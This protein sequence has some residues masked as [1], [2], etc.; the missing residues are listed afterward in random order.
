MLRALKYL[1]LTLLIL[2][3]ILSGLMA[4]IVFAFD[5]NTLKPTI[6][7]QVE[8]A[9]GRKLT[10]NGPITWAFTPLP[11][12]VINDISFANRAGFGKSPMV[13]AKSIKLGLNAWPRFSPKFT[14]GINLDLNQAKVNLTVK[15]NGQSNWQDLAAPAKP[16][17]KMKEQPATLGP[18]YLG[19]IRLTNASV[20][21]QNM[22][23]KQRIVLN[24]IDYRT[25]VTIVD[26]E[27]AATNLLQAIHATGHSQIK[28]LTFNNVKMQNL[29]GRLAL[30][31]GVMT[32][33]PING[34]LY[35]GN[36][37]GSVKLDFN[38]A[39]AT[40]AAN[41]SIYQ[42]RA[43]LLFKD[44]QYTSRL[45]GL[46]QASIDVTSQN[47]ERIPNTLNGKISFKL[48]NGV[49]KGVNIPQTIQTI[50]VLVKTRSIPNLSGIRGDT[51]F[52]NLS[53]EGVI[54]NGKFVIQNIALESPNLRITGKG[55]IDLA[56]QT[57]NFNL[58]ASGVGGQLG[59]N[60]LK[61]QQVMGGAIP[62]NIT[63]SMAGFSLRPE[64]GAILPA[65]AKHLVIDRA[66]D[67]KNAVEK[68]GGGVKKLLRTLTD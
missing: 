19:N 34:R 43:G 56:A 25:K 44:L 29:N 5:P 26:E 51:Q 12:V 6:T 18:F 16:S 7:S 54:K 63:G 37:Q 41:Q 10:I 28:S 52:I 24:G 9:T 20:N 36:Y 59:E 68:V 45:D 38:K 3:I 66:E 13:Q 15:G 42:V 57:L 46:I 11:K 27:K 64:F 58:L 31:R 62:L 22:K 17:D 61:L 65:V 33:K 14:V 67:V 1:F 53:G 23:S 39:N 48:S 21:W 2:L 60:A 8:E 55:V 30:N 47:V 40:L 32:I 50:G 35:E 4:Y 49:I